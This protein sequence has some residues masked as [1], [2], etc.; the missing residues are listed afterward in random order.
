MSD[1]VAPTVP[2]DVVARVEGVE[3]QNLVK[4]VQAGGTLTPSERLTFAKL[5]AKYGAAPG[6]QTGAKPGDDPIPT[7]QTE[8]P[9]AVMASQKQK[10]ARVQ[11]VLEWIAL[12]FSYRQ[13]VAFAAKRWG[14]A[15]RTADDLF[16]AAKR[17]M[18]D[19][20]AISLAFYRDAQLRR[21]TLAYNQRMTGVD[22]RDPMEP[23]RELGKLL[24]LNAPE[25]TEVQQEISTPDGTP[26]V[27]FF[28][29]DNGRKLT[30]EQADENPSAPPGA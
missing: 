9:D 29:P 25:R 8:G 30:P 20:R 26:L 1:Q 17:T 11:V 24:G 22:D 4:K 14:L 7:S 18:S 19:P 28:I 10:L 3:L 12:G 16:A 27:Q 15:S 21:L 2:S 23:L 5:T 13:Q 6:G